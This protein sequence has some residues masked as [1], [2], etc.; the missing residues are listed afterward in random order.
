MPDV[1]NNN[2][3]S[4]PGKKS[5]KHP[6]IIYANLECSLLKMN[7]CNNNPN[8]SYTTAKALHKPSG[9]SLLTSCSFDKSKN[10]P[11]YYRGKD[12]VKIFC[13]DLKEH[14]TRITNY[15]MKQMA[16]LTEEEKE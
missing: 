5:L 16:P 9:Y 1:D 13:D 11:T 14:V 4:K 2:L 8:K 12:C 10:K 3:G 15:E 6:F 7:T